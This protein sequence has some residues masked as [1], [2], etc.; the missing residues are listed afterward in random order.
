MSDTTNR[1]GS[2]GDEHPTGAAG[3]HGKVVLVTGAACGIGLAGADRIDSLGGTAVGSDLPDTWTDPA[4]RPL[5]VSDEEATQAL[6]GSVVAE[7]GRLDGLVTAAGVAGGGPMHA[8]DDAEW[9]RVIEVNLTGTFLGV[10]HAVDAMLAQDPIDGQRG[11]IVTI[12]SV[13]GMEGTAGGS[14]YNASKGGVILL[15]KNVAIDYGGVGIRANAVCPGF[16]DTPMLRSVF[17]LD[18]MQEIRSHVI[19]EHKLHRL[20]TPE[21]IAG[22]VTFLLSADSSFVTGHS[23]VVDGGYTAGRD[24]GVTDLYGL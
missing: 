12:A 18:G 10:R 7:H 11:S 3:L 23:L 2:T 1:S 4:V 14:A 9:R 21:E 5:D 13:E 17:D 15:T 24:H 22:P 8:I 20:G 6:I 19:G 16:I